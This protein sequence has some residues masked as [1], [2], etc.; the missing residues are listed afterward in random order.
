MAKFKKQKTK[1]QQLEKRIATLDVT[2]GSPVVERIRGRKLARIRERILLRDSFT[3]QRCGRVDLHLE[4]DHI[5]PLHL[6]GQETDIN[7]QCLCV[8]CHDIKTKQEEKERGI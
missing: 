7:R 5:A 3:C 2:R 4:V 6:G 8:D 1:Y